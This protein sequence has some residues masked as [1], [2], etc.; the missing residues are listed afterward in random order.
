MKFVTL[1]MHETVAEAQMQNGVTNAINLDLVAQ[2]STILSQV[3][4][5]DQ[6]T[7]LVLSSSN[8]KFFSNGFDL[9]A[10]YE[11]SARDFK[12][13]YQA[14]NRLCLDLY[15][16][17]KP[18]VAAITGH[19]IAGGCILALCCDYRFIASGHKLMGLNE[20]KLGIPVPYLADRILRE[21]VGGNNANMIMETG[22]FFK[23]EESRAMGLVDQVVP[24]EETLSEGM[25]KIRSIEALSLQAY[26]I[27]KLNRVEPV[28]EWLDQVLERKM[29]VFIECWFSPE[30]RE[31]LAEARKK[32]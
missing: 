12:V 2:L 4:Q 24:V 3:A 15:T 31:R 27:I 30:A 21:I 16:F 19:A 6:I 8:D 11:L 1:E 28:R 26:E 14:F 20:I 5:N 17:S 9:P 13:F 29:D 25:E 7:G 10:L 32:F 22:E 18:T 23:P